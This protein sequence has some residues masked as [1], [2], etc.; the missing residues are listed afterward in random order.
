[1]DTIIILLLGGLTT[2]M[3]TANTMLASAA[4]QLPAILIIHTIGLV[5]TAAAWLIDRTPPADKKDAPFYLYLAGAFGIFMTFSGAYCIQRLGASM[6]VSLMISGQLLAALIVDSIGLFSWKKQPLTLPRLAAV[7]V[8]FG[9]I[10]AM[11]DDFH[12]QLIP[13]VMAAFSGIVN[14][15]NLILNAE[16]S[17]RIGLKKGTMMNFLMGLMTGLIL[18]GI[19]RI[20]APSIPLSPAGTKIPIP[21]CTGGMLGALLVFGMN[22][23]LKKVSVLK[24]A[25]LLFIGQILIGTLMDIILLDQ[26]KLRTIGGVGIIFLALYLNGYNT[27]KR[28]Y[29]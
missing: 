25:I 9:G 21:A 20:L 4:G 11:T 16:L 2:A 3:L 26:F 5:P 12:L 22:S 28:I 10:I 27:G 29:T 6:T 19:F 13:V 1:M 23:N 17:S 18:L 15:A 7:I 24:S 14:Q 8:A